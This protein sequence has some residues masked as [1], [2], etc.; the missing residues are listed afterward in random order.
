[1]SRNTPPQEFGSLLHKLFREHRREPALILNQL[2][3]HWT[4]IAG[5]EMGSRTRPAKLER[6]TLWVET[7]DACW[8]Y[9][10]QFFKQDLLNSIEAFI[11][12]STVTG[13]RFS[14]ARE[15]PA[16]PKEGDGLPAHPPSQPFPVEPVLGETIG[17]ETPGL[18]TPG[19]ET[20]GVE[21]PGVETMR[22]ASP[23]GAGNP[24]SSQDADTRPAGSR[25]T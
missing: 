19:V 13:L 5:T 11:K 24:P 17:L 25:P 23:A 21:T 3:E 18:E 4:A 22:S 15:T 14:V 1:M 6:G 16:S 20:P 10:L 8:A 2:R 12:S 9:E 7:P